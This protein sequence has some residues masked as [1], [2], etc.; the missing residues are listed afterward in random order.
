MSAAGQVVVLRGGAADGRFG[1]LGADGRA[2]A[3]DHV[4]G[5]RRIDGGG[6]DDPDDGAAAGRG[7]GDDLGVDH[8]GVGRGQV[9][10]LLGALARAR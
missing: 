7:R 1:H 9:D 5:G 2:E 6:S 4:G 3:A 8:V 10:D